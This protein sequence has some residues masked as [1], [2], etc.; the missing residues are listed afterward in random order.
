MCGPPLWAMSELSDGLLWKD[1]L[2]LIPNFCS[3]YLHYFG[4]NYFGLCFPL[5]INMLSLDDFVTM[6]WRHY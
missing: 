3:I 2:G 6:I 5:L 1:T 4:L